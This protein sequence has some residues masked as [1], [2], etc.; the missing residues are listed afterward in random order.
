MTMRQLADQLPAFAPRFFEGK[1]V[2][3]ATDLKGA[4][5]FKVDWTPLTGGLAGLGAAPG[6]E[7]DTGTTIFRTMEKNLGLKLEQREQPMPIIV[8]HQVDRVPTEN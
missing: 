1:P 8:I 4:W 3:D 2:L 7:F 5:D 6:A